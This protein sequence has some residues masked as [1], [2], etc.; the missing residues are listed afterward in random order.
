M[1]KQGAQGR[2]KADQMIK[3]VVLAAKC[4]KKRKYVNP[5]VLSD[6]DLRKLTV[7]A[8]YLI[9]AKEVLYA[10]D[11]VVRRLNTVAPQIKTTVIPNASHDITHSQAEL[12]NTAVLDFLQNA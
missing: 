1:I 4:F 7:P 6:G 5:T 2:A 8:L 9:G 10:P 12:V 11:K 3:E